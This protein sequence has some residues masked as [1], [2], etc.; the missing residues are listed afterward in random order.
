MPIV[1]S[2]D[3]VFRFIQLRPRRP[4]RDTPAVPLM[5]DTPLAARLA[6]AP[7]IARRIALA[8]AA[9]ENS[10]ETAASVDDLPLGA[11]ITQAL[12]E[13]SGHESPT[14]DDL[15]Q[16]LPSL[17]G[18][19]RDSTIEDGRRLL[20]DT[21]LATFF[22]TRGYPDDLTELQNVFRVYYLIMLR[23]SGV[24]RSAVS[25][26]ELLERPILAPAMPGSPES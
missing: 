12:N 7:T 26:T 18:S 13:L 1:N 17:D 4:L 9:L 19:I 21:L 23:R 24:V 25:L 22:A 2:V 14:T 16:H 3:D 11:E 5:G 8:N 20:S 6:D 15:L 10:A